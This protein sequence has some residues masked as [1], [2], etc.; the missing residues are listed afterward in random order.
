MAR[1]PIPNALQMRD[2]KYGEASEAE[3]DRLAGAL[4]AQGRRAEALLLYE[5]QPNHPSLREE[6]DWAAGQG[7]GF[8][9][10]AVQRGGREIPEAQFRACAAAAEQ[11]GRWMEARLC[12]EAVGDSAELAR[13][14]EHLPVTLRP[15]S[16]E[17]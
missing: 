5:R 2:V 6:A 17:G 1:T 10:L 9:L 15:E 11:R 7:A 13:I 12:Y 8:H 14:A 16:E 3:R 4:R